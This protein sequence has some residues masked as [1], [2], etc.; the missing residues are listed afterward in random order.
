MEIIS[1]IVVFLLVIFVMILVHEFGH[2]IAARML[3]IGVEAFAI[4][5]GPK[6]LSWQKG[7]TEYRLCVIP[8]GGYCKLIAE[9]PDEGVTGD[10]REFLSRNRLERFFVYFMGPALNLLLAFLI[11]T[12]VLMI[13]EEKQVWLT[14]APRADYLQP[15]GPAELAGIKEGDLILAVN[16]QPMATWEDLYYQIA[17]SPREEMVLTVGRD[18]E[19]LDY[20]VQP[21]EDPIAGSGSIGIS[22]G[23][24]PTVYGLSA[25]GPAAEAGLLDGDQIVTVNGIPVHSFNAVV[26]VVTIRS[27]MLDAL[28]RLRYTSPLLG[29]WVWQL[30]K[31]IDRDIDIVY[32]RDGV[33]A[34]AQIKPVFD[35]ELGFRKIGIAQ[36]PMPV[37]SVGVGFFD[38]LAG[39]G[40][41]MVDNTLRLYEVVSKMV[42]GRLGTRVIS[43][44]V[45]IA[46]ISGRTAEQGL[47][48]LLNLMA[49]ISLNLGVLNLL[50]LPVLDGGQIFIILIEGII[51]RDISMKAKEWIMRIGVFLLLALMVLV[52]FQDIDKF[53]ARLG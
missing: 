50:P 39:A 25:G 26:N 46:T 22:P 53:I 34:S 44:P 1:S 17:L 28:D 31:A 38:A 7:G 29:G 35:P 20:T 37:V 48:P 30:H 24:P 3:G 11:W 13:G 16:G 14:E 49:F 9:N 4:G 43:G 10:P 12:G 40:G 21:V 52:I 33:T 2:F 45:E 51:R 47:I 15:T 27:R 36:P 5:F 6:L 42:T 8:L 18:G 23:F 19:R 32:E 41:K